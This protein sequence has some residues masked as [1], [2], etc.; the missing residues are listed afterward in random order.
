MIKLTSITKHYGKRTI[1]D[2]VSFEI[3]TGGFYVLRGDSGCGKSTLLRI[4]SGLEDQSSGVVSLM[5][6]PAD[7]LPPNRRNISMVFQHAAIF[8]HLSVR[9][10]IAYGVRRKDA[11]VMGR[12]ELLLDAL[13]L[14][15]LQRKR[16]SQ[17]SGGE[18][19]RV[20]IARALLPDREIFLLDEPL[21]NLD[22]ALKKRVFE[23]ITEYTS[24]KTVL[25]VTHENDLEAY[26]TFPSLI[27]S[28]GKM[29]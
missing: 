29:Q 7:K 13:G 5:E 17:L 16:P 14:R 4:I 22:P 11:G 15:E 2:D 25:Y 8:S 12:I 24:G 19:K 23:T 27:L 18:M 20:A 9:A 3:P 1:L 21:T 10:N 6:K 26:Q 28:N